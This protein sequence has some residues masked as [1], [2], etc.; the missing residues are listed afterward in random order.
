MYFIVSKLED[1]E[2]Y[3]LEE[4]ILNKY[5]WKGNIDKKSNKNV[6]SIDKDFITYYIFCVNNIVYL[7]Y[8]T[9]NSVILLNTVNMKKIE[10]YNTFDTIIDVKYYLDNN[11]VY[12]LVLENDSLNNSLYKIKLSSLSTTLKNI[13][14]AFFYSEIKP[15]YISFCISNFNDYFITYYDGELK[16]IYYNEI[17]KK[18][19]SVSLITKGF[20][21][22]FSDIFMYKD[23]LYIATVN[24]ND[25][26]VYSKNYYK[27]SPWELLYKINT[28]EKISFLQFLNNSIP[29]IFAKN[30]DNLFNIEFM[31]GSNNVKKLSNIINN[32]ICILNNKYYLLGDILDLENIEIDANENAKLKEPIDNKESIADDIISEKD[33]T[34]RKKSPVDDIICDEK[35]THTNEQ[36][37]SNSTDDYKEIVIILENLEKKID[38]I[39]EKIEKNKN[40]SFSLFRRKS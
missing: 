31:T 14:S 10:I 9:V 36:V 22:V 19:S 39:N 28:T 12:L 34:D 35:T 2:T 29:Q 17:I 24:S 15:N 3:Y 8:S 16:S 20:Y 5:N 30:S 18:W 4:D 1:Y 37:V 25:I 23:S 21:D 27:N 40:K 7:I 6:L 33:S 11:I 32:N 26:L 13:G 38:S